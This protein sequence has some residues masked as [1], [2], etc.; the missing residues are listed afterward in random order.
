MTDGTVPAPPELRREAAGRY[1]IGDYEIIRT[2]SSRWT[3]GRVDPDH[4]RSFGG[5]RDRGYALIDNY[6]TLAEAAEGARGE[7]IHE[8]H[9]ETVA[10]TDLSKRT[11][12]MRTRLV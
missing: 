5:G 3:L 10:Q 11:A 2:G 4:V 12:P 9:P 1:W 8:R 7:W 6:R